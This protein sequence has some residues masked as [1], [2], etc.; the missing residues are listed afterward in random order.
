MCRLCPPRLAF[1]LR[2]PLRRWLT[3]FDAIFREAGIGPDSRVLEVGAGNGFFTGPLVRAAREVV[4]VE[5]Q[6]EM[7]RLLE[8]NLERDGVDRSR[9]RV[10]AGD[11]SS[12]DLEPASIDVAFL[13]FS[14]HEIAAPATAA[15]RLAAVVRPGGTA[16]LFE[17]TVEVGRRA[18]DR[19]VGLFTEA[20][21]RC[22]R[23]RDGWFVRSARLEREAR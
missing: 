12:I 5:V 20:G 14:F 17:P 21:F 16:A 2:N 10:E 3:D 19:S 11:V 7:V 15:R 6:P 13:Y 22:V 9:L 1:V 4:A 18:M 8:R 23:R